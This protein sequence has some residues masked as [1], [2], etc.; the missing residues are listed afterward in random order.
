MKEQHNIDGIYFRIL[1]D[2]VYQTICFSDLTEEEM[3]EVMKNKDIDWIRQLAII[4]GNKLYEIAEQFD[5][6]QGEDD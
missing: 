6:Y 5:I 4:L 2:D 1:R 3:L